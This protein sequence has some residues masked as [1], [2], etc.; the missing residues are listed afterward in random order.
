MTETLHFMSGAMNETTL[1]SF[2]CKVGQP[3]SHSKKGF[4]CSVGDRGGGWAGGAAEKEKSARR[5][6]GSKER[7]WQEQTCE[8]R[9]GFERKLRGTARKTKH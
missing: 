3:G 4:T 9:G 5:L 7:W 6:D 2:I 1:K 8:R